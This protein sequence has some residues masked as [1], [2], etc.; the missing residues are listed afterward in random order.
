MEPEKNSLLRRGVRA[1]LRSTVTGIV[2][3]GA[4]AATVTGSSVLASRNAD[5]EGPAAA[6]ATTVRTVLLDFQRHYDVER[7]FTGEFEAAQETALAFELPGTVT[8]ILFEEGDTVRKGQIV[9]RLDNRILLQERARLVAAREALQ[10]DAEL[11]R[12][13][14]TR[15]Q[16]LKE[17]GF[18]TAQRVD[19]TSL[20]L[21]RIEAAIA[22]TSAA[23]ASV[24]IQLSKSE[25][26]APF[27]GRVSERLVDTGTVASAGA[28]V[29]NFLE[30]AS[31]SFRVGVAPAL[32]ETLS[33]GDPAT[34]ET[35]RGLVEATLTRLSPRL[36]AF[37]RAR[38]AYFTPTDAAD[39]FDGQTGEIV[40]TSR[41]ATESDGAWVP[42]EALRQG[43]RGSWTVVTVETEG[44]E[45]IAGVAAV[46]VLHV[47]TGRAF[48]RGAFGPDARL[49]DS[50]PHRVVPGE[51]V[52]IIE[53]NEVLSWAQ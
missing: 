11:A 33:I 28:P 10:A 23:I 29:L 14:N 32:A 52:N 42:I 41:I 22:E 20:A 12:R 49:V 30:D 3:V 43:P 17:R 50:G 5:V 24:D 40:L 35:A 13:T 1:V 25:L 36:D 53:S 19:N 6:P 9:A 18:A 2:V 16:E 8:E 21:L 46:E 48:V 44:D 31:Q 15:Q 37:T 38:T 26:R 51:R 27:D 34:I 7:R 47:D 45:A 39:V 4:V